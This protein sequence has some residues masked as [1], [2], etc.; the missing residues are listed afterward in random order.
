M[1]DWN[2]EEYVWNDGIGIRERQTYLRR[3]TKEE[4]GREK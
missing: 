2:L 4:D 1:E 3:N